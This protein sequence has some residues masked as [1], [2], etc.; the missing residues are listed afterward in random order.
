[1]TNVIVHISADL[2]V[3][4][5]SI[6]VYS[7]LVCHLLWHRLDTLLLQS[8]CTIS[9]IDF[10]E[11]QLPG[12]DLHLPPEIHNHIYH[13]VLSKSRG[14]SLTKVQR[15]PLLATR[16]QIQIYRFY[17]AALNSS[18][19]S[20]DHNPN[21]TLR[22]QTGIFFKKVQDCMIHIISIKSNSP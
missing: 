16:R 2:A 19:T 17:C 10:L 5:I 6:H 11:S 13:H 4:Y 3:A 9:H 20:V 22:P 14:L 21:M 12:Q 18:S 15:P 1:V 7:L 8:R